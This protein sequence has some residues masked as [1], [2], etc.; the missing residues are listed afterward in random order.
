MVSHSSVVVNH[1]VMLAGSRGHSAVATYRL[2]YIRTRLGVDMA[3]TSDDEWH[4]QLRGRKDALGYAAHRTGAQFEEGKSYA[5]FDSGGAADYKR[6]KEEL[7]ANQG[8]IITSVLSVRREDAEALGMQTKQD[9]SR[10]IRAYWPAHLE[11]MC[12]IQPHDVRYVCAFHTNSDAN[13]HAHIISWSA[14]GNFNSLIP[15]KKLEAARQDLVYKALAPVRQQLGIQRTQERDELVAAIRDSALSVEL[16]SKA[17]QT[18]ALLPETGSLKYG[19]LAMNHPEVRAQVDALVAERLAASPALEEKLQSCLRA[20]RECVALRGGSADVYYAA[21]EDELRVRLGNAQIAQLKRIAG[22]TEETA[23][24]P[25]VKVDLPEGD[26]IVLPSDRRREE[27]VARDLMSSLKE[28]DKQAL[29]R[30]ALSEGTP[31]DDLV[32]SVARLPSVSF[33]AREA[34]FSAGDTIGMVAGGLGG[35]GSAA[36]TIRRVLD[37]SPKG[38][39]EDAAEISLRLCF[40]SCKLLAQHIVGAVSAPSMKQASPHVQRQSSAVRLERQAHGA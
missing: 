34:G 3:P 1:Q 40:A 37:D 22:I 13:F 24:R 32:E 31:S 26:R 33:Y 30:L 36:R 4:Q 20:A 29:T 15:K 23:V 9:F 10:F 16:R 39:D 8:S 35:L 12:G 14:S 25:A 27:V 28:A 5:L 2:D 38:V 6:T 7:L 21:Y 11:Q 18:A 17:V 19:C